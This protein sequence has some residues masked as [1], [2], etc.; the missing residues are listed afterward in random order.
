[1]EEVQAGAIWKEGLN[2]VKRMKHISSEK[3]KEKNA[4]TTLLP[5]PHYP[6]LEQFI[7]RILCNEKKK[8]KYFRDREQFFADSRNRLVQWYSKHFVDMKRRAG[9]VS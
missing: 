6:R 2:A 3:G 8:R 5:Q 9:A 1:M 7:I 4:G